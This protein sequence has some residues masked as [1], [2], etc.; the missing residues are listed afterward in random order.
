MEDNS[1][2]LGMDS[3]ELI[4]LSDS[5]EEEVTVVEEQQVSGNLFRE[6]NPNYKC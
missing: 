4:K 5:E 3:S 1:T 6:F 2:G